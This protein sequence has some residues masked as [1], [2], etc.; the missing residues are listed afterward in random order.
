MEQVLGLVAVPTDDDHGFGPEVRHG[1]GIERVQV[2]DI[3]EST[4][5][6]GSVG[7]RPATR[8][9]HERAG[10]NGNVR[11]NSRD[12]PSH[13]RFSTSPGSTSR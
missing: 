13:C 11:G 8:G 12:Q 10:Q 5:I 2:Q 7:L 4:W 1:A 9:Y 6:F 3:P